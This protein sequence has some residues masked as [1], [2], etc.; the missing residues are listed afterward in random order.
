M[1]EIEK[2]VNVYVAD[3][4]K[5]FLDKTECEKY[6]ELRKDIQYFVVHCRP[7]LNETGVFTTVNVVAVHA[8]RYGHHKDIV[9]NWCV[10]QKGYPILCESVQGYGWQSGFSIS[11]DQEYAK[12]LWDDFSKDRKV[13]KAQS[14]TFPRFGEKVFLSEIEI[15]GFPKPFDYK[16][17]WNLK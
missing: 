9:C 4:G 13:S 16:K 17:E 8:V 1:K 5:E 12:K 2:S 7:D 10:K 6:E 3:D 14:W 15:D 11:D